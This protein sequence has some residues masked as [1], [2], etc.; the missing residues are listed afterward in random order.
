MKKGEA[1]DALC[2]VVLLLVIIGLVF[3]ACVV[4]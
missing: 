2:F 3:L 1:L 4:D